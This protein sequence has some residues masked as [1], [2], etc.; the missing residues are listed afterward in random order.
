M[1][2]VNLINIIDI[3]CGSRACVALR[4]DGIGVAWSD[5]DSGGDAAGVDLK[6]IIDINCS[7]FVCVTWRTDET[8]IAWGGVTVI[9]VVMRRALTSQILLILATVVFHI[10]LGERMELA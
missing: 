9:S 4:T 10:P 1:V 2:G 6:D 5:S 8:G 3:S 7:I